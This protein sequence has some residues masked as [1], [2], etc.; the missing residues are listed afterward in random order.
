MSVKH[1]GVKKKM[2]LYRTGKFKEKKYLFCESKS[3]SS[4]IEKHKKKSFV[5]MKTIKFFNDFSILCFVLEQKKKI[6]IINEEGK[7]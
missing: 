2:F 4:R 6:T 5:S 7:L 3:L 1:A